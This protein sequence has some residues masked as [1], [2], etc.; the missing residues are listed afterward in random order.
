M[1][2]FPEIE[3]CKLRSIMSLIRIIKE[4]YADNKTY[5]KQENRLTL[6]QPM[7]II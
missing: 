2:R 5:V 1:I 4:L 3:C 6:N 7:Y